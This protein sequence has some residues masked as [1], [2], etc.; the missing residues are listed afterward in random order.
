MI[1]KNDFKL[2]SI[3]QISVKVIFYRMEVSPW[4]IHLF[5]EFSNDIISLKALGIYLA[6]SGVIER[7]L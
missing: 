2:I 4:N 3:Q 7:V 5:S 1:F 6:K